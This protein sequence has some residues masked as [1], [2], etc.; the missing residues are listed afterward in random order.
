MCGILRPIGRVCQE[1]LS[2]EYMDFE[3]IQSYDHPEGRDTQGTE[4][5]SGFDE[6]IGGPLKPN[7]FVATKLGLDEAKPILEQLKVHY[8]TTLYL[9]ETPLNQVA[10]SPAEYRLEIMD[11]ND[12]N[13]PALEPYVQSVFETLKQAR[14]PVTRA[15]PIHSANS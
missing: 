3:T 15:A 8:K 12:P 2:S 13:K 11:P 14:V 6:R 10:S 5:Q 4:H 1:L 9:P 7:E